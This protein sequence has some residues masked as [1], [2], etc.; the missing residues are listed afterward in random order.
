MNL[1]RVGYLLMAV[2]LAVT[3]WPSLFNRDKPWPLYEGTNTYMLVAMGLL[4]LLGLRHPVKLLPIL[5]FESAWK[6]M[7]L[8]VVARPLWAADQMDRDTSDVAS[9]CLWVIIVIAVTPWRYVFVQ[10]FAAGG[11]PWF[12]SRETMSSRSTLTHGQ[13]S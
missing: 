2:G 4:A 5:V 10:Y 11:D 9:A 8:V 3:E 1:M 13:A 12:R 7:W 6:V